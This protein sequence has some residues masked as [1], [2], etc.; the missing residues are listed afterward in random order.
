MQGDIKPSRIPNNDLRVQRNITDFLK[1]LITTDSV[2]ILSITFCTSVTVYLQNS[3]RRFQNCAL[4]YNLLN[5]ALRCN[6]F[7]FKTVQVC[8]LSVTEMLMLYATERQCLF[9]VN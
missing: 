1:A 7:R 8:N 2:K 9:T 4:R 5:A 3:K 6:S